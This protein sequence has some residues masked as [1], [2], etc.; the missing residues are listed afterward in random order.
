MSIPNKDYRAAV[1]VGG[2]CE[3]LPDKLFLP[4]GGKPVL[5]RAIQGLLHLF[6]PAEIILV[7]ADDESF[8]DFG[9]D[10][11][12][13]DCSVKGP[14]AGIAGAL[15]ATGEGRMLIIGG[16]MPFVNPALLKFLYDEFPKADAVIPRIGGYIEP[17]HGVYSRRCLEYTGDILDNG[18]R[19]VR[20]L[21]S[22]IDTAFVDKEELLKYDPAGL[23]W[24][25][26]NT[27]DDY[28]RA[29]K[30]IPLAD[31]EP[32]DTVKWTVTRIDEKGR[33]KIKDELVREVTLTITVNDKTAGRLMASP[34]GWEDLAY[35]Y[36]FCQGIIRSA[37][38]ITDI[39]IDEKHGTVRVGTGAL[40][41]EKVENYMTSGCSGGVSPSPE[42][43][44]IYTDTD[45]RIS[46]DTVS[47]LMKSFQDRAEIYR[48]T[49]GVHAAAIADC[50]GIIEFTA[51]IG[52]HNAI[53]RVIGA[54]IR[55]RLPPDDK[56]L[57]SSGRLSSEMAHKAVRYGVPV[58]ASR[59]A[60]THLAVK[61]ADI[62]GVT[63]AG[64]VRGKRMNIYCRPERLK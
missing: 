50:S 3:R 20:A 59:G 10:T 7:G 4:L 23:S 42:F 37:D 8:K 51:D 47:D 48:E 31:E 41:Y 56:I 33:E 12:P 43:K 57:L 53:D 9:I 45:F 21:L 58:V 63:L 49:G 35:G 39:L 22:K 40:L 27:G 29:K 28:E 64:F 24:F 62:A 15:K 61:I 2:R 14:L 5:L 36:L 38:D 60:P 46:P 1:L 32:S 26:L 54:A 55:K 52:R 6:S 30:L 44:A 18:D 19:A 17:L 34:G 25:N 11:I 13:D 16:D